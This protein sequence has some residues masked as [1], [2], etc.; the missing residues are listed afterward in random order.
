MKEHLAVEEV[1]RFIRDELEQHRALA[2][3]ATAEL[4]REILQ[5]IQEHPEDEALQVASAI[6]TVAACSHVINKEAFESMLNEIRTIDGLQAVEDVQFL[7]QGFGARE[8]ISLRE[9]LP[10]RSDKEIDEEDLMSVL[11][12]AEAILRSKEEKPNDNFRP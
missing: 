1:L 9:A 7:M 4:E 2:P 6:S 11:D 12:F 3:E 5:A 10:Q 8:R